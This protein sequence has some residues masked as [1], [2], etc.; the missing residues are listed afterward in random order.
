M[1]PYS[2]RGLDVRTADEAAP[3]TSDQT[4]RSATVMRPDIAAVMTAIL[5]CSR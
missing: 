4:T 2:D 5:S 1:S 3:I